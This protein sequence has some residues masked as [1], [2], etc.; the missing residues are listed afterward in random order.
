M[1]ERFAT[2]AKASARGNGMPDAPMLILPKTE[3]TEYADP[4]VVRSLALEAIDG[5]VSR[6]RQ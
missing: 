1:T 5:I 2:L 3:E 6:W 4:A